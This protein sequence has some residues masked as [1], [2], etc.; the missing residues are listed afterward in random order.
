M[1]YKSFT[2]TQTSDG[3]FKIESFMGRKMGYCLTIEAAKL[4]IDNLTKV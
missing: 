3:D 2:I 4:F 1:K